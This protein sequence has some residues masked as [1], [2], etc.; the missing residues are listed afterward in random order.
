MPPYCSGMVR[1]K[2]PI[3]RAMRISSSGIASFSS[4][5]RERGSTSFWMKRLTSAHRR[6]TSGESV[7]GNLVS[8]FQRL[9]QRVGGLHALPFGQDEQWVDIELADAV[10]EIHGQRG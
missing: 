6:V 8:G 3:S 1:P 5:Q 2:S 7:M 9:D 4:I 10:L